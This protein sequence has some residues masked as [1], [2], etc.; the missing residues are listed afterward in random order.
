MALNAQIKNL[1]MQQNKN[2]PRKDCKLCANYVQL[3]IVGFLFER[4]ACACHDCDSGGSFS[5]HNQGNLLLAWS[6]R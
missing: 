2:Y 1:I 5:Q 6:A 4:E 3:C